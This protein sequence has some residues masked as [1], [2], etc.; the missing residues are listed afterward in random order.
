MTSANDEF[1][2]KWHPLVATR[3]LGPLEWVLAEDVSMGAPPYWDKLSGRPI[4]H[5]LLG[6]IVHNIEGF[7]YHREWA[8]DRELA[9]EFTGIVRRGDP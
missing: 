9:L 4:V 6:L 7:S 1:L 8:L 2:A 5:H 3:D